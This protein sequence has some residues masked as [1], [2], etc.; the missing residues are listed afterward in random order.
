MPVHLLA[1]LG[2]AVRFAASETWVIRLALCGIRP[3]TDRP[4]VLLPAIRNLAG[5]HAIEILRGRHKIRVALAIDLGC[6]CIEKHFGECLQRKLMIR[7]CILVVFAMQFL[8]ALA[9]IAADS[10]IVADAFCI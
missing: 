3:R 4:L 1:A 10:A 7:M 8:D 5:Q 9:A 2:L 6:I